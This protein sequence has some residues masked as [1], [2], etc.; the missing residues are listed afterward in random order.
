MVGQ[1]HYVM[2]KNVNLIVITMENVIM[3]LVN[4]SKDLEDKYVIFKLVIMDVLE[5]VSV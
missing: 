5:M 2:N 4:V 1:A 3:E